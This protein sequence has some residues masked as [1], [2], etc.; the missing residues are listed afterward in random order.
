MGQQ[1]P[2]IQAATLV[3]LYPD[4]ILETVVSMPAT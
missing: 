2:T 3:Y 1:E 4:R